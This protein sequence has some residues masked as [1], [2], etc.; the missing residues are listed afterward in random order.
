[1]IRL[2]RGDKPPILIEKADEWTAEFAAAGAP[3][4]M[5]PAVRYRYRHAD[6]KEAV[7]RDSHKKCIYCESH[8]TQV[9]PGEIEHI[10][11]VS[12]RADLVVEWEN[13]A[14]VC[15]EC[16]REK[17]AYYEPNLPLLNPFDDDPDEYLA[18]YGPM[19]LHRTGKPRGEI[20]VRQLKLSRL[21][22]IERRKE[23]IE[24]LQVLIDRINEMPHGPHRQVVDKALEAEL[25]VD[26]EYAATAREF[27]RQAN[28]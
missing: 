20:T 24:R 22:L 3:H 1:M 18:F 23:R 4:T 16:N 15:T 14:F 5:A 10:A 11:P 6:I 25:A 19:V 28:A 27:V 12:K 9:H 17:S 2:E 26:T 8:I 21:A 7:K 13:L